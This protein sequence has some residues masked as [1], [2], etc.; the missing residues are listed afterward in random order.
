[1][2]AA[3]INGRDACHVDAKEELTTSR[4]CASSDSSNNTEKR[5]VREACRNKQTKAPCEGSAIDESHGDCRSASFTQKLR[6]DEF[7]G[8]EANRP[9]VAASEACEVR[10]GRDIFQTVEVP[11]TIIGTD[12]NT[13]TADT[14]IQMLARLQEARRLLEEESRRVEAQHAN[15]RRL[16]DEERRALEEERRMLDEE[17]C[18]QE[19]QKDDFAYR[20][21][22][23]AGSCEGIRKD[24]QPPPKFLPV[25]VL[26]CFDA[27]YS[28]HAPLSLVNT[29][30]SCWDEASW[31][32]F[33]SHLRA[34]SAPCRLEPL[35]LHALNIL[36]EGFSGLMVEA[37]FLGGCGEEYSSE[38]KLSKVMD[39]RKRGSP[40]PTP[41]VRCCPFDADELGR[42]WKR[43]LCRGDG[44]SLWRQA[45]QAAACLR[46]RGL[47]SI[48]VITGSD[49]GEP[50][51]AFENL[52]VPVN[53]VTLGASRAAALGCKL[54]SFSGG[55][56]A[57]LPLTVEGDE[58]VALTKSNLA[59]VL[60]NVC[61]LP[62]SQCDA[63]VKQNYGRPAAT[64]HAEAAARKL[65]RWVRC[66][67]LQARR[68]AERCAIFRIE[69]AYGR[70]RLRLSVRE[71]ALE[72]RRAR[73][74]APVEAVLQRRRDERY[75]QTALAAARRIQVEWRARRVR[76]WCQ[77]IDRAAR[78]LQS[79]CRRRWLRQ[80]LLRESERLRA[81]KLRQVSLPPPPPLFSRPTPLT[82]ESTKLALTGMPLPPCFDGDRQPC[83]PPQKDG[84]RLPQQVTPGHRAAFICAPPLKK[85]PMPG[86]CRGHKPPPLPPSQQQQ[87]LAPEAGTG[88]LR[89]PTR[90]PLPFLRTVSRGPANAASAPLLTTSLG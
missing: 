7:R 54:A 58:I 15:A 37:C 22:V 71:A 36:A 68:A 38:D 44:S 33:G 32:I 65:Q 66:W 21:L 9:S 84:W 70:Y 13:S 16:L 39:G 30:L 49:E 89:V 53:V 41:Y 81:W 6:R 10:C 20:V 17:R 8:F 14:E 76:L 24:F 29:A 18:K 45:A 82:G 61:R 64:S 43:A 80:R 27:S 67:L 40:P 75:A 1:M 69:A 26:V 11:H 2:E 59:D 57:S 60:M 83:A 50:G 31:D 56:C 12:D 42:R 35:G 3:G 72:A 28:V 34:R 78:R 90:R 62:R 52:G 85:P 88:A 51:E 79:W 63:V 25:D 5:G 73:K 46:E 74:R 4:N 86:D 19:S 87:V 48:V 47:L 23:D 77:R 55:V